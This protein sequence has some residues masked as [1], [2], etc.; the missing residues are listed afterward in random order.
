MQKVICS[1]KGGSECKGCK[2]NTPHAVNGITPG[3]QWQ[4]STKY[5]YCTCATDG[6]AGGQ[7]RCFPVDNK[8]GV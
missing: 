8:E 2:H 1:N 7:V 5:H 4:C 3:Y 6:G